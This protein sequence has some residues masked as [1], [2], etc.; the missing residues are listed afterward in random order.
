MSERASRR[1]TYRRGVG[2]VAPLMLLMLLAACATIPT[3]GPV[4]AGG[5]LRQ[6]RA[7]NGVSFIGQPPVPG[8]RPADVVLGFLQS[9]ADF[10]NDHEVARDYLSPA[11]RQSWRPQAGT[12]VYDRVASALAIEAGPGDTVS[13]T[14]SQTGQIEADG[15]F[16]RL[17]PGSTVSL[18]FGLTKVAGEWRISTLD[19]GLVLSAVDVAETYRR[20]ALYFLAPT[21]STLVPD[22]VLVPDL[23]G[24]RTKLV[25]R[26]LRGPTSDLR[27]AVSTAFPEGTGL[28]V[29][30]VP[31]S[32]DG[33]ATVRLDTSALKAD[34][35]ARQRMS[36]QLVW[37]LRQLPEVLKVR[38]TAGGE[39]LV[40][41]GSA[42][43]QDRDAYPSFDPDAL[44]A[45]PSAY[46]V[47]DGK[48]GRFLGGGFQPVLGQ[49]GS[50]TLALRTPAVSL[51]AARLAAVSADGRT[52]LVGPLTRE[53]TL[54]PRINGVDLSR[55][56][57]DRGD[58]L[59]VV[60][61]ATGVVWYLADGADAPRQVAVP[62]L[63]GDRKPWALSV[64][65]DG[66]RAALIVGTG[67]ASVLRTA[68]VL[69]TETTDTAVVG[70]AEIS[71]TSFQETLPGLTSVRDV[72]WADA[73]VLA[74]LGSRDKG[75][76][77]P[78]YVDTD[79]YAVRDI[80]PLQDP[81]TISAAP[82]LA[83]N[84]LVA[85]TADGKLFQFTQGGGW[86]SL[87]AGK[88]PAY[89]G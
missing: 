84:P 3:S 13:V 86:Q 26:L 15:R 47:T 66:T 36:A 45:P 1:A 6:A 85:G 39:S 11:A 78:S 89:P 79:G 18:H 43:D 72:A 10:V 88:D 58:N 16:R 82:P 5:D 81:V 76:V 14:G 68:A 67:R 62:R 24:L 57:W 21:G 55:P 61:R 83:D 41:A 69:R 9:S 30:S 77:S 2:G 8:A 40:V 74:V 48:V 73:S 27:D 33:V 25:S 71:L 80:E 59:W 63:A 54:E 64:A 12:V 52:V 46:V 31:L 51:D 53:A 75:P 34:D 23:P 44:P 29:G 37:T 20:L 50:G 38:I 7:D 65:R 70:G 60:D 42:A 22:D 28:D 35:A 56:S 4:R 32:R 49:A 19:D 17:P 87:G